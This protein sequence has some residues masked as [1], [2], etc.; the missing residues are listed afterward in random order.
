KDVTEDASGYTVTMHDGFEL[1]LSKGE[2]QL[3]ARSSGFKGDDP[4]ML[5]DANF[6]YAVAAKRAQI[7]NND[8]RA[9]QSYAHG[10]KSLNDG[11]TP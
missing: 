3:A 4:V 9:S 1:Y 11:D 2:L 10:V 5:T 8:G 7:D 6:I